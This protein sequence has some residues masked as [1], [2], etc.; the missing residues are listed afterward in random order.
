M[1][2][3]PAQA[4]L[5]LVSKLLS[6]VVALFPPSYRLPAFGTCPTH[7]LMLHMDAAAIDNQ[8]NSGSQGQGP[9]CL[10][11]LLRVHA[12]AAARHMCA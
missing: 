6:C 12:S 4:V 2:L 10:K 11:G 1:S 9:A 7:N 8:L 3:Q 5:P